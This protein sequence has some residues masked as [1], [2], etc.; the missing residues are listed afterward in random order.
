MEYIKDKKK[1]IINCNKE[2]ILCAGT[3]NSPKILQLSGIG[4]KDLLNSSNVNDLNW[5]QCN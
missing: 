4:E 5:L 2:I 3:I 1:H